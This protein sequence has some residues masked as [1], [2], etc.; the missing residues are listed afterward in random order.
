MKHFNI[1]PDGIN[2]DD[3]F[4]EQK[5]FIAYLMGII[6]SHENWSIQVD[7]KIKSQEIKNLTIKDIEISQ[8]DLDLAGL[9]GR[10]INQIKAERLKSEKEKRKSELDKSFGIKEEAKKPPRPEGLP[11][12]SKAEMEKVRQEKLWELLQGKGLVESNG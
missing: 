2:K 1:W 3:L 9:Q 8:E 5:V 10:D 11:T 12:A 6:P 7:Y 4:Y